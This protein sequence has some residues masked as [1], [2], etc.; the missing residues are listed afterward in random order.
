VLQLDEPS[1]P[2]V[3]RGAISSAS[4]LT[5]LAPIEPVE[6]ES[7]FVDLVSA[8]HA[9]EVPVVVHSCSS[10]VPF[11]LWKRVGFDAISFDTTLIGE[12]DYDHIGTA[13]DSGVGVLLGVVP[14]TQASESDTALSLVT[15]LQRELGFSDDQWLPAIGV[16]PTCGLATLSA[17]SA[18]S[19][20]DTVASVSKSLRGTV[21]AGSSGS[22]RS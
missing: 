3:L 2:A 1:L 13:I 16:S 12:S 5:S 17:R 18:R 19:V 14:T 21:V 15:Q 20:I 9:L 8:I 6:V 10:A 11:E 7:I 4:G 22:D